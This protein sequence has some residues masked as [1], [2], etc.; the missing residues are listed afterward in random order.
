MNALTMRNFWP[1][2]TPFLFQ[3]YMYYIEIYKSKSTPE[4]LLKNCFKKVYHVGIRNLSTT[5]VKNSKFLDF[6]NVMF[7][8]FIYL[9]KEIAIYECI[10]NEEF[11]ACINT[12]SISTPFL[13]PNFS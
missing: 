11:L 12:I 2:L 6:I 4:F 8:F 10:D 1:A 5:R 7:V 13:E 9:N 3:I